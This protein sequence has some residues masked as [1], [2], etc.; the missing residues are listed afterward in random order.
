MILGALYPASVHLVITDTARHI[1]EVELP[2]DK[3]D[4][5]L[6]SKDI[7]R[8]DPGSYSETI[9]SGSY[10]TS[11]MIVIPASMGTIGRIAN[12]TSDNLIIRTTDVH[13]KE[14]RKL[15]VVPRETPL[16]RIHLE[17]LL[18]LHDAGALILPAMPSFYTNADSIDDLVDTVVARVLD[19]IGIKHDIDVRYHGKD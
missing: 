5:L 1:I 2:S 4:F 11:G 16:N 18:K 8:H 7:I 19:H 12:G 6:N 10:M 15:I 17:N 13:L 9:A 14:K 3:A